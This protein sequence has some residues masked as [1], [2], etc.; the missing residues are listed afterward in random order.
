M[1]CPEYVPVFGV[2]R[3]TDIPAGVFVYPYVKQR[4]AV[5]KRSVIQN[6]YGTIVVDFII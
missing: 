4:L 1:P 5:Y 3:K 6:D 2:C